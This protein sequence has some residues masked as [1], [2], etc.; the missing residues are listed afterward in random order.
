MALNTEEKQL[1]EK[2]IATIKNL[3]PNLKMAGDNKILT[4]KKGGK[5]ISL[6][7]RGNIVLSEDTSL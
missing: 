3:S 5:P 6:G 1:V 2:L 4:P 7:R